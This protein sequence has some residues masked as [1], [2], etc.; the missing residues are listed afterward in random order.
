[1]HRRD[2][3]MK[4]FEKLGVF[5]LGGIE[6][7]GEP[8]RNPLLYDARNLTTHAVCVG[9]TGSGKTGLCLALLE[10]AA[11]D[12]IP[13]HRDRPQGRPGQPAAHLSRAAPG[14]LPPWVDEGEAARKGITPDEFAAQTAETLEERPGRLGTGRPE[15]IERFRDAVDSRST[16]RAAAPACRCRCCARSTPRRT[17]T[18]RPAEALPRADPASAV[19]GLL[20][21]ARDRRRPD[22]AAASTSCSPTSS[23]TPGERARTWTSPA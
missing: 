11:I 10:E 3:T 14:G 12:G 22:R 19:A 23:T 4:D 20:R 8:A 1:M 18:D 2:P 9:M 7:A 17:P 16:R 13:A 6:G 15:R 21:P 5:Y